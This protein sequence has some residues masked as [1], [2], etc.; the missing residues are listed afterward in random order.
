MEGLRAYKIN[1]VGAE[2]L[3]RSARTYANQ[4]R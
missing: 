4:G 1:V 2:G 3:D